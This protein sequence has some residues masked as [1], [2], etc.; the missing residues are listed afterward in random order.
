MPEM[1]RLWLLDVL[2]DGRRLEMPPFS[3]TTATRSK[4]MTTLRYAAR[5][6][7]E[8]FLTALFQ[9]DELIEIRFIESWAFRGR[10]KSRVARSAQWLR[11]DELISQ[12][13]EIADFARKKWANIYFGVCP[14]STK[15]IP[16]TRPSRPYVAFGATLTMSPST[17]PMLAL[18]RRT[19]LCRPSS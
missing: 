18:T 1:P 7:L 12:H 2:I 8:E 19:S 5:R 10:K 17:K 14:R 11:R 9:P 4:P 6:Q 3:E 13:D 16:T 15:E